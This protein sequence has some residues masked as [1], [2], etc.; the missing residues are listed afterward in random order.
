MHVLELDWLLFSFQYFLLIK[1][2]DPVTN[3][4]QVTWDYPLKYL[5]LTFHGVCTLHKRC[6]IWNKPHHLTCI[7]VYIWLASQV[8]CILHET[9]TFMYTLTLTCMDTQIS[10]NVTDLLGSFAAQ[11]SLTSLLLASS[12]GHSQISPWLWDKIWEWPGD[13]TSL[14]TQAN[15][16]RLAPN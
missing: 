1:S 11:M 9:H 16:S 14:F 13:K 12:P 2:L 3:V 5:S 15:K 4:Q 8:S 7:P 6:I 10:C